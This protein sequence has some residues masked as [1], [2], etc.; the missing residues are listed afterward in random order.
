MR[1]Q[2]AKGGNI[3][4]LE[5]QIKELSKDVTKKRA[6]AE[7]Q[8]QTII[9]D[10]AALN[11]L[12]EASKEAHTQHA[13]KKVASGKAD[14]RLAEVKGACEASSA[15]LKQAE[16]LLQSLITGLSSSSSEA[17][18][19]NSGYMGQIAQA[20]SKASRHGTEA[21]QTKTRIDH[22]MR[23]LKDKEP[24]AKQAARDDSGLAKD[25][26]AAKGAV[27]SL[28]KE[29]AKLHWNNEKEEALR[30]NR[31][32]AS[33]AVRNLIDKR[34][35]LRSKLSGLDFQYQSPSRDFDRSKVKGL[36]AT[37]IELD[38][39]NEK[40]STAL[41]VC[42]GGR[43]YN[44][45]RALLLTYAQADDHSAQVVVENEQVG[46]QL[47]EHGRLTKRVTMI[48]LNQIQAFVASADVRLH[49]M[50]P[51]PQLTCLYSQ[52]IATAKSV[53]KGAA[54][55]ALSLV[56][57]P[58]DVAKAMQYV[59]GGTLICPTAEA[60]RAVTFHKD[61]R[62]KSVTLEGDVYDPSGTLSGGSKPN[63]SG[64]LVKAQEL[65][66]IE[67]ELRAA[68][69][70]LRTAEA[71]WE[72][73]RPRAERWAAAQRDLDLKKHEV[74]L[75]EQRFKESS[76]SKVGIFFSSNPSA[77]HAL[78]SQV[79]EEVTSLKAQIEELKTILTTAQD[80]RKASEAEAKRL[81][82]EMD[83]FKNNRESKLEEL[84][85]DTAKKKTA[86]TKQSNDMK[87]V[88]KAAQ[89]AVLELGESGKDDSRR[90]QQLTLDCR[91][92][93]ARHRES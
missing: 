15:T 39:A 5:A 57:Y 29:L 26:E 93:G 68:Q 43:L 42:A 49:R 76:A 80:A 21:E 47:L 71:E 30:S 31:E 34:D 54:N 72:K 63:T 79:V 62:L 74:G 16:G 58:E 38:K 6:Q 32:T 64:I 65:A 10:E 17:D 83:E 18:A 7:L 11:G 20:K 88:Q 77:D 48:P 2:E 4:A 33:Q 46:S 60:A 22:V 45:R 50:S 41:E 69:D 14:A 87:A 84:K 81:E 85:K 8:R 40:Y 89:T 23:E 73:A 28:E 67:T 25:L 12:I 44:V 70:A 56:G 52:K 78:L 37:L 27:V 13:D 92:T 75:L 53:S 1:P 9:D 82:K 35:A 86:F 19:T 61:I 59:F 66:A 55:L 3:Q 51:R 91:T 90:R 24:K 36:V